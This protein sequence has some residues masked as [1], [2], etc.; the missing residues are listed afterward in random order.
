MKYDHNKKFGLLKFHSG[1]GKFNLNSPKG[2]SL[3]IINVQTALKFYDLSY[4]WISFLYA[5]IETSDVLWY[6]I[7]PSVSHIMSAQ[8]LEKF[9][10]DSHGTWLEDWSWSVDD[11]YKFEVTRSKVRVTVA[12]NAKNHVFSTSSKVYEW[13]SFNL[14]ERLVMVSRW[15]LLILRSVGLMSRSQ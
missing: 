9:L 13:Q 12:F 1:Y 4:R 2:Y 14:V 15:P 10:S 7:C 3:K 6:G 8:Y 11:P 5:R